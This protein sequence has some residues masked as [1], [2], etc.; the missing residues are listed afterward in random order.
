MTRRLDPTPTKTSA[1]RAAS[2]TTS[3]D[4]L[5][6][7]AVLDA[8]GPGHEQLRSGTVAGLVD[9]LPLFPIE[10][11][12]LVAAVSRVPADRFGEAEIDALTSDLSRLAL[13]ALRHEEAI[14][15]LRP[16]ADALVPL[17]F[18]AVYR[19]SASV[20]ELLETRREELRSTLDRV[21]HRD[22][23]GVKAFRD[24]ARFRSTVEVT[25]DALRQLDVDLRAAMPGRAYLLRKQRER[26]VLEEVERETELAAAT[27]FG[28]LA[29]TAAEAR[30]ESLP[31]GASNRPLVLKGA[32]LMER[33]RDR[34][35]EARFVELDSE[36][37]PR[38]LSLELTGPW[39]PYSFAGPSR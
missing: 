21:R 26:R 11:G 19:E 3:V 36:Y 28:R 35:L 31:P 24:T 39:A 37:A 5:Y 23:W 10:R 22:E 29:S 1:P 30:R 16:T 27:I 7:Y 33:E 14:R 4:L 34:D 20:Q 8:G 2:A 6:L 9:G 38:G 32:L 13:L 18:G 17:T 25:S 15:V 12:P